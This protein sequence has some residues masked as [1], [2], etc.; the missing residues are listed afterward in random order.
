MMLIIFNRDLRWAETGKQI[1]TQRESLLLEIMSQRLFEAARAGERTGD[2][3][4]LG[5]ILLCQCAKQNNSNAATCPFPQISSSK[6][7][8]CIC[9][10]DV[11]VCRLLFSIT[12]PFT[13]SRLEVKVHPRLLQAPLPRLFSSRWWSSS[14]N[15]IARK[16]QSCS[17][18]HKLSLQTSLMA[19]DPVSD[20][21]CYWVLLNPVPII[22]KSRLEYP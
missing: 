3:S 4:V 12:K 18:I 5:H 13:P 6:Y 20:Q 19:W 15:L 21:L 22:A 7:A 9:L 11:D 16:P 8:S 2:T 10:S 17:Q 1:E 14:K